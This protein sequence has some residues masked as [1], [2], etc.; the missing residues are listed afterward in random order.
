MNSF[1]KYLRTK[2]TGVE[3]IILLI[4]L[5][6]IFAGAYIANGYMKQAVSGIGISVFASAIVV[7]L[8]DAFMGGDELE[9][10]K[11]WG[12]EGVYS[13]RGE[14]NSSCDL[15]LQKAK[16][17]NVIAFGL[18]SLR[19]T[20]HKAI[21]R[22]LR[23]GGTVRIITMRPGCPNLVEREKDELQ[24]EGS[25]S[26]SVKRLIDW[27]K[28]MNSRKYKG[29]IEIRYHEKQPL[30]FL[31]MMDNRLFTGPYEYGKSS[32]QTISFEYSTAGAAYEYYKAYFFD[33]WNNEEFCKD[34]LK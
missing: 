2:K 26:D 14:M 16:Y 3:I 34:A 15:Y 29:K 18:K 10:V 30:D 21:E 8:T 31:F 19:D 5:I 12:F 9:K 23:N 25:I 13:T 32:Q 7:F 6:F 4:G 24:V 33:L 17:V 11:Q 1:K 28:Q 20:Q 27:A 22:I